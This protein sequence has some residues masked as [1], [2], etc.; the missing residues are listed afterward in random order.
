MALTIDEIKSLM[1]EFEASS[2]Q[3][4]QLDDDQTH[5]Y[6]SKNSQPVSAPSSEATEISVAETDKSITAPLVGTV[7]LSPKPGAS[8]FKQVGDHVSVGEVVAI[9][10]S[11]KLMTEV[12][13][14]E[15]GVVAAILVENEDVVGF[16]DVLMTIAPN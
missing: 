10:E 2:L 16:N 5:L 9:I 4:F 13:S 11:M 8:S 12:K 15:A 14:T 7:Y 1:A 6:L 3:E